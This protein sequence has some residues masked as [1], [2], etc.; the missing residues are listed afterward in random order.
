MKLHAN[1][2]DL[3]FNLLYLYDFKVLTIL[4]IDLLLWKMHHNA[5]MVIIR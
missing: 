4:K 5:Y 3:K 2:F 1:T